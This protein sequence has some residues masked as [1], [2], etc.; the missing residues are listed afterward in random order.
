[1]DD[2]LVAFTVVPLSPV[3]GGKVLGIDLREGIDSEMASALR[4][5]FSEYSVLCVP[6]QKIDADDQ[7]RFAAIFGRAD[8]EKGTKAF[9][10]DDVAK[11]AKRGVMFISNR[12]QDGKPIGDLPDGEMHFHSDGSH[13]ADPY[14]ATTLF[15]IKVTSIGGETKFANLAAAYEALPADLKRQISG[16]RARH[17]Y[18]K[19]ATFRQQTDENDQTLSSAVHGLVRV[20]PETGRKSLYLSRLMTRNIIGMDR[21]E[22]DDLLEKLCTHAERA[23]FVY[24]HRWKVGDLLIWDNRAVNHARNDFPLDQERHLRRVTVS[25]PDAPETHGSYA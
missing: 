2:T 12:R 22:S 17:V 23:E 20:H 14:R 25:E 6:D 11:D 1:M 24:A 21:A 10:L 18:D 7:I 9:R 8:A 16:L 4:S 19:R 3:L 13:R 5:A 15:A